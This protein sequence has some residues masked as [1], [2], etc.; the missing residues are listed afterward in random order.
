MFVLKTVANRPAIV[1]AIVAALLLPVLHFHPDYGHGHG[2]H[3]THDSGITHADFFAAF[4]G[5]HDEESSEH[6]V[7][8]ES[9]TGVPDQISLVTLRL[10]RSLVFCEDFQNNLVFLIFIEPLSPPE[11]PPYRWTLEREHSP[12]IAAF[13]QGAS[14]PRS[15]P[16]SV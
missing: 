13:Y 4:A 8:D 15:P 14:S 5:Y 16:Q 11:S 3:E 9:P 7:W 12:P 10:P 2:H 1:C 6:K